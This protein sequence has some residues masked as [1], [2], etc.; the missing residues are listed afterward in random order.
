MGGMGVPEAVPF[1][2]RDAAKRFAK[3]HGGRIV[4]L[5]DVPEGYIFA[6]A[7]EGDADDAA[8]TEND[9]AD[10]YVEGKL[11]YSL[12]AMGGTLVPGTTVTVNQV[13]G[14]DATVG[15]EL[16]AVLNDAVPATTFGLKWATD[17]LFDAGDAEAEQGTVTL[18][19]KIVY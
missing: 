8:A 16:R 14:G 3:A 7:E 10:M 11:D 1:A 19:T 2:A 17:T 4:A 13:D 5:A 6:Y 9:E 18:W 12:D 15:L